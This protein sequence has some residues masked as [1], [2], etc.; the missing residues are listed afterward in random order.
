M[1]SPKSSRSHQNPHH[2]FLGQ[3]TASAEVELDFSSEEEDSLAN[4]SHMQAESLDSC[5]NVD[6]N[7]NQA[8]EGLQSEN[9][10]E[11]AGKLK[12]ERRTGYKR[13]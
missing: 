13:R 4:I 11:I 6:N 2:V 8:T 1:Q 3:L 7:D 9:Q 5:F 12:E 10:G